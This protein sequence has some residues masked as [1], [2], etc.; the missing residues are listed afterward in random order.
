MNKAG[1]ICICDRRD[2]GLDQINIRRSRY[3]SSNIQ[4]GSGLL[5]SLA[6]KI[7]L[8]CFLFCL[9]MV[10]VGTVTAGTP[11]VN[12][13][14][15]GDDDY[16]NYPS[17]PY[18]TSSGGSELYLT[19]S[20]KV[21]YLAL[22]VSRGVNDNV[23][24][25]RT[26][27]AYTQSAGWDSHRDA[28]RA[29]DSEFAAF[30]LR[31]GSGTNEQSWAWQQ[32]TAGIAGISKPSGFTNT[33]ENWI[34]DET[35]AGGLGIPPP[36]V[37]SYSSLAWN[38]SNYAYRV[39]N[40]ID[41]GWTMGSGDPGNWW[42]PITNPTNINSVINAAEGYPAT[43]QITYSSTYEWE[44]PLVY[45]W[46]LDLSI[47]GE[48]PVFVV[49]GIS[50]HS[51]GKGGSENDPFLPEDYP[52]SPLTDFGDLPAP[53]PSTR[54]GDGARHV[55]DVAGAYLGSTLD[56]EIDGL[57]QSIGLGDDQDSAD[58]EDGV[59]LLTPM[60]PGTTAVLRVTAGAPGALSAFIDFDGDYVL[61]PVT[62]VSAT[63]VTSLT[64]GLLSDVVLTTGVYELTIDIPVTASNSMP[65]RFRITNEAGQG[66]NSV[67]GEV[68]SGEVEDY[69]FIGSIS[70]YVWADLDA[71]GIQDGGETGISNV[72]VRLLD[73]AGIELETTT[74]DSA[75]LYVF[76]SLPGG[77]YEVEFVAPSGY[78]VGL[79][80]QGTDDTLDSD[81]DPATGRASVTIY[82][83]V[84]DDSI[85]AG[86]ITVASL[87]DRVWRDDDSDGVQD[88]G[89]PG[90]SNVTVMLYDAGD[91]LVTSN[92]TDES[93]M[94]MFS[95]LTAGTYT[96]RIDTSTLPV[97]LSTNQTYDLDATLDDQAT[98][99]LAVGQHRLDLDFGYVRPAPTLVV[100]S[101]FGAVSRSGQVF[102][103]WETAAELGAVGFLLERYDS[104][105]DK[106]V[107]VHAD[108]IPTTL[109]SLGPQ[110]YEVVDPAAVAGGSYQY[111]LIEVE[112]TGLRN[113]YGPFN[114]T[115][116]DGGADMAVWMERWFG[117]LSG[118]NLLDAAKADPDGDGLT[119]AQE[120]LAQ[121]DPTDFLSALRMVWAQMGAE[122]I[123][124]EW[125]SAS[126]CVYDVE[127]ST[128]LADGFEC[129]RKGI[130]ADPPKNQ[131]VVPSVEGAS[132]FYRVRLAQ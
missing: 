70:D 85:D 111:R 106:Y 48:T 59:E 129:V 19:V 95:G 60:I 113:T 37:I 65:A 27:S 64:T 97:L 63:G 66:G 74:T 104:G 114:V 49:T 80:N 81:A 57:P 2:S 11:T 75:G 52:D 18:A 120:F 132:F 56:S 91:A 67:T 118:A 46:S 17:T 16:L 51:P 119:N 23:F 29:M 15:Y 4:E 123:T 22:V 131:V 55:I 83:G 50:H 21:L 122:G 58:D 45:E 108:L 13:L 34:S 78:G 42:S 98:G 125:N 10:G 5:Y 112:N 43:N 24:S 89:E 41:P 84:D 68:A 35:V 117:D 100:L 77:D 53:Y 103:S 33:N 1:N 72:T 71:D 7:R 39:N 32:G 99:S 90:I 126:G 12:G 127:I 47:F 79:Q 69:I 121:T 31:V 128:N 6:F 102:V 44:W 96:V 25:P 94:Y 115:V 30:T 76:S 54:A 28:K 38:M 82:P 26:G 36:G 105:V 3:D 88:V 93:G 116:D 86:L 130:A 8:L 73:S 107:S 20:D 9:A 109:F 92:V 101:Q 61:D 40:G 14:F 62:F 124:L 110:S 87:G